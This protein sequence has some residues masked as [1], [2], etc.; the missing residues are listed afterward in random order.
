VCKLVKSI[1][2]LKQA[3][4]QWHDKFDITLASIGFVANEADKCVY[5][6]FSGAKE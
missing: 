6:L 2:S 4:K 1:Y 5:Y 3:P